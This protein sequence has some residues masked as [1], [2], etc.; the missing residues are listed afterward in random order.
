[1]SEGKVIEI[2]GREKLLPLKEKKGRYCAH[3]SV[4]VDPD[5]RVLTCTSCGAYI[6]A[7][8]Y[9]LQL[10]YNERNTVSW[11]AILDKEKKQLEEER[12]KLKQQVAYLKSQVRKFG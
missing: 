4:E 10:A 1:M 12:D 7:F 9:V 11:I 5:E 6:D 3:K 8:G 2:K